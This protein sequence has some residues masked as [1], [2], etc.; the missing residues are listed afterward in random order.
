[1][2]FHNF[3]SARSG[4]EIPD[5]AMVI[6][7]RLL[8]DHRERNE[9]GNPMRVVLDVPQQV[10]VFDPVNRSVDMTVHD[11]RGGRNSQAMRRGD[12][13]DPPFHGDASGGNRIAN[14]LIENFRRGAWKRSQACLFEGGQILLDRDAGTR[15]SI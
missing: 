1:M 12:H 7:R 4:P 10:H 9:F 5:E 8:I 11:C 3:H 2:H 14:F 15:C 6:H 13:L